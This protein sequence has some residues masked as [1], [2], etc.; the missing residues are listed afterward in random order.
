MHHSPPVPPE[1]RQHPPEHPLCPGSGLT[2][3]LLL[4]FGKRARASAAGTGR[5]PA[6][7][8]FP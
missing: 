5:I 3:T 7:P 1:G 6:D 8:G 2:T 4:R